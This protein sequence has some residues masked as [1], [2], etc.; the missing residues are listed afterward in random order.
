MTRTDPVTGERVNFGDEERA[1]ETARQ[2][3][4][5]AEWCK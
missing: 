1:G 2:R 5:V 3:R 4:A